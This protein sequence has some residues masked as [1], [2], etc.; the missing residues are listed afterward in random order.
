MNFNDMITF[1]A[2]TL[3]DNPKSVYQ[4]AVQGP[5]K[6]THNS[7]GDFMLMRADE[8]YC[9]LGDAVPELHGDFPKQSNI[10]K[11]PPKHIPDIDYSKGGVIKGN[12]PYVVG[13]CG[14]PELNMDYIKFLKEGGESK[15]EYEA[16]K[17]RALRA[18]ADLF[19]NGEGDAM[20][21][22]DAITN[23]ERLL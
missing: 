22:S 11:N 21:L 19:V 5:I 7:H 8:R 3:H 20:N 23:L 10:G 9:L 2:K 17:I 4:A 12:K 6:L 16:I 13:E 15:E 14:A 18:E 1:T